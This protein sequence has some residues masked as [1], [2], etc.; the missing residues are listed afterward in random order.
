MH[1][2]Q[3]NKAAAVNILFW[4]RCKCVKE[5]PPAAPSGKEC[6]SV[7]IFFLLLFFFD[8]RAPSCNGKGEMGGTKNLPESNLIVE[9]SELVGQLST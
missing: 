6:G 3:S 7:G 4:F 5:K 8:G 1:Q 2:I 9:I